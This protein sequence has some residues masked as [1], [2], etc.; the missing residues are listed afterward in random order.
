M[1]AERI[2]QLPGDVR[3]EYIAARCRYMR[4]TPRLSKRYHERR[5]RSIEEAFSPAADRA[6]ELCGGN[7]SVQLVADPSSEE[8]IVF[9]CISCRQ[10]NKRVPWALEQVEPRVTDP[11]GLDPKIVRLFAEDA[12]KYANNMLESSGGSHRRGTSVAQA[13]LDRWRRQGRLT[14]AQ[15]LADLAK[16]E[17]G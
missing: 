8:D 3:R 5:I 12:L 17:M 14:W 4:W 2:K 6:C 13:K 10:K 16:P 15:H 11:D 1:R 7:D 9:W